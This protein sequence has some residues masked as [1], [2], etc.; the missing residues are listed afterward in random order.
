MHFVGETPTLQHIRRGLE[1]RARRQ[2]VQL[3]HQ[4]DREVLRVQRVERLARRQ[5]RRAVEPG[6][7]ALAPLSRFEIVELKDERQRGVVL[8]L[9]NARHPLAGRGGQAEL[10]EPG[11][12]P[13]GDRRRHRAPP[14]SKV[15]YTAR[16]GTGSVG[17]GIVGVAGETCAWTSVVKRVRVAE[18]SPVSVLATWGFAVR[19][20][21]MQHAHVLHIGA[22]VG[23]DARGFVSLA[24]HKHHGNRSWR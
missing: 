23:D 19:R 10:S 8:G 16:S 5:P 4:R 11:R 17:T 9:R 1:K 12:D 20:G 3:L 2:R 14:R 18:S 15:S 6:N 22:L 21:Q 24:E 7:P 13:L